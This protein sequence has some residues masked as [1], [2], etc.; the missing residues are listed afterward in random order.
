MKKSHIADISE[1][2]DLRRTSCGQYGGH[3]TVVTR[4]TVLTQFPRCV[5]LVV[6]VGPG[7]TGV[8]VAKASACNQHNNI[9]CNILLNYLLH[10]YLS[11]LLSLYRIVFLLFNSIYDY[12]L[13]SF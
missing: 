11:G 12:L 4:G 8:L 1:T 7:V 6:A 3:W 9:I 13:F 2:Q 5:A 10:L